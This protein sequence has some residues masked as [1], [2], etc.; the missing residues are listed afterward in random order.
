MP[1]VYDITV[2]RHQDRRAADIA[3]LDVLE[4]TFFYGGCQIFLRE[5]LHYFPPEIL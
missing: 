5:M 4:G 3:S 2:L 1:F